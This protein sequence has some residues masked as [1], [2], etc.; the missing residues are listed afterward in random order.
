MIT[1][2]YSFS[3]LFI[4]VEW[5][6]FRKKSILYSENFLKIN[7]Y[8]LFLFFIS[9]ILNMVCLPIG[10]FT[11]LWYLYL[12]IIIIELSKFLTLITKNNKIINMYS[13]I[14]VVVYMLV[15][16]FIFVQGVVL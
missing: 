6:Q 4:W 13:L 14:S 15:Y 1:L 7:E 12:I 11:S 9:K 2:F 10:L 3:L 16:V 8:Q 5:T